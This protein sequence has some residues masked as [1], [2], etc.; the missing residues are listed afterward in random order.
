[1]L[2]AAVAAPTPPTFTPER[3][4]RTTRPGTRTRVDDA[5]DGLPRQQRHAAHRRTRRNER[6]QRDGRWRGARR[7]EE[8]IHPVQASSWR[9]ASHG[10]SLEPVS[11]AVLRPG[12]R[13]TI[14]IANLKRFVHHLHQPLYNSRMPA[15]RARFL[16]LV[17]A[18]LVVA[19]QTISFPSQDGG[20][21]CADLYG[22]GDRA[23][24]R[25][26][27]QIQQ[28]EL[29]GSGQQDG[30]R[31]IRSPGNRLPWI[32]LLKRSGPGGFR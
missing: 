25:S 21:I 5:L 9:T 29:A 26:R 7:D 31:W 8:G 1:V 4:R 23:V 6:A 16:A 32:R 18:K 20:R 14:P 17:L 2:P 10:G 28:G 19:Q 11:A 3:F 12:A 24:V 27:R 13:T 15:L 30:I 22:K